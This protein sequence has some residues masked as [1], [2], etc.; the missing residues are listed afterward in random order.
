MM[1]SSKRKIAFIT[2]SIELSLG[3]GLASCNSLPIAGNQVSSKN[4]ASPAPSGVSQNA[5]DSSSPAAS[6]KP[7][8]PA[9]KPPLTVQ[10]LKNATYYVLSDGPVTLKNG[11][12]QDKQKR[13]FTLGDVVAYGDLNKDG[14]KDAVAPLTIAINDRTFTYLVGSINEAGTPKNVVTEFLGEGA[15]VTS[16]S[17]NA[18][19][20]DVTMDKCCPS[21]TISQGFSFNQIKSAQKPSPTKSPAQ[22]N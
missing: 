12:Y 22:K 4:A 20:I 16:L 8:K 7:Q 1:A 9:A 17:A 18:G 14:I 19:K 13:T 5:A 3:I 11:T 15:T 2:L 6:P 21:Q 10:K